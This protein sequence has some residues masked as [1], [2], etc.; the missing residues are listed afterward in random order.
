MTNG[1]SITSVISRLAASIP[2]PKRGFPPPKTTGD[3]EMVT[4]RARRYQDQRQDER[5]RAIHT[6]LPS[7]TYGT[8]LKARLVLRLTVVTRLMRSSD[9]S[10]PSP[11]V[12]G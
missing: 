1:E 8:A 5:N 10:P 3:S 9:L 12:T 4:S 7:V 6:S 2:S 11:T